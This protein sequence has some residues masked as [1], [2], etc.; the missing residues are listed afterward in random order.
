MGDAIKWGLLATAIVILIALVVVLPFNEFINVGEFSAA[1]SSVVTVCGNLFQSAR[2]LINCFL[3]PFG[4]TLV[5]GMLLWF[6]GKWAV[7]VGI[8]IT[9]WVY[10]FIFK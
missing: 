10:H 5:T 4:R 3:T 8:K 2:G 7:M 1:I 9:A 6:F